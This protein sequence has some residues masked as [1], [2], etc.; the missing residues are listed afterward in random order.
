MSDMLEHGA[1]GGAGPLPP[2]E[3][4]D[5]FLELCATATT[6][7]LSAEERRRLNAH[8]A[9]CESCREIMAQYQAIVDRVIPAWAADPV[10][11]KRPPY[12]WSQD[13][14]EAQLFA[15]LGEN[16]RSPIQ[17]ESGESQLPSGLPVAPN[18]RNSSG[19][20]LWSHLWVQFAAALLLVAALGM[21]A[22]RTGIRRGLDLVQRGSMPTPSR[23]ASDAATAPETSA[24]ERTPVLATS[25]ADQQLATLRNQLEERAAEIKRL[26]VQLTQIQADLNDKEADRI[27]LAQQRADLSQQLELASANLESVQQ[28]LNSLNN[29]G[30][31]DIARTAALEEKANQLTAS[32]GERDQE[33]A[34]ERELLDKDR[35][36]REL[37]SSRDLYIAEVYDVAK[38]GDTQKPFGRVF[39]T[40]GKSLIF[41]AYDLDQQ[42]GIE[43]PSTFQAW[44]R[45]GPDRDHAVNLGILYEDNANRKRWVLKSNNPK[46]LEQ[47]DAVFVTVE[48][49]GGSPHPSGKPLLFAYLRIHPNH[50]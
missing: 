1:S 40:S 26:K 42:P 4:H 7:S 2:G 37:M 3:S 24:S 33:I 36:I 34:R 13:E 18:V 50:P 31:Q 28:K 46:T 6:G 41:Y 47:I 15:R 16:E 32:I 48:P 8:L 9:Q 17:R 22:Y 25:G 30:A 39:Y 49:N 5:E 23:P 10:E 27:R 20:A 14:A 21:I 45:R 29:Q 44:G 19:D 12:A 35:D 43:R 38:T 11:E